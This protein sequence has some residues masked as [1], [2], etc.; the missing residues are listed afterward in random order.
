MLVSTSRFILEV[1]PTPPHGWCVARAVFL[2]MQMGERVRAPLVV[3]ALPSLRCHLLQLGKHLEISEAV[4]AHLL[5]R[6]VRGHGLLHRALHLLQQEASPA[7][8][9]LHE[10][11]RQRLVGHRAV[12]LLPLVDLQ[13][14]LRVR[15]ELECDALAHLCGRML[16]I[17]RGGWLGGRSLRTRRRAQHPVK[18]RRRPRRA[19]RDGRSRRRR[20]ALSAVGG[21]R[22]GRVRAIVRLV[23]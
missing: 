8:R 20:R 13:P 9:A 22:C 21:R 18:P 2:C 7:I 5:Q 11:I 6:G 4:K 1:V 12:G 10:Q 3:L 16:L 23:V 14:V 17:R 19:R 15:V